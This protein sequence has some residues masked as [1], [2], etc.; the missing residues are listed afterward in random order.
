LHPLDFPARFSTPQLCPFLKSGILF[1]GMGHRLDQALVERGLCESREKARR[2]IMA[3]QVI[4]NHQPARKPS[5]T[6]RPQD[7]ISL[8]APE[9]YVSRGGL[10]LEHALSHFQL[11]VAG[12]IAVDLGASTGGFTDCLLQHGVTKVYAVDVGHGQLA[13]KLRND[14]RVVVMEKTNARDLTPAKFPAPFAPVDLAV[15]DCSFISLSRILPVAIALLR[16]SGRIVALIK[17]QFEAGKAEADKGR[18]VI[19]D[20]AIHARVLGE[21][22]SFVGAQPWV[23]WRGATESPLLGP[24]GNKEF[25]ALI[26]KTGQTN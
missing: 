4:V 11:A 26:E 13:W 8:T 10:K 6:A 24:A 2:A 14:P 20:P 21:I 5:D 23:A 12:Q 15:I 7:E 1:P 25:F 22:E 19:T 16:T 17:P 18:G 3:G 9:K